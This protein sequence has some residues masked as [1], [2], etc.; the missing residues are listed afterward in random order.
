L[1]LQT[2]DQVANATKITQLR[3]R[4]REIVTSWQPGWLVPFAG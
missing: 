2:G 4:Q 1:F 3:R